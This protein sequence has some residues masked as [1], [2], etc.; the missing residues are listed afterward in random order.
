MKRCLSIVFLLTIIIHILTAKAAVA[1]SVSLSTN[2]VLQGGTVTVYWSGFSGGTNVY[3]YNGSYW[4]EANT[5]GGG[6]GEQNLV[7]TGYAVRADYRVRVELKANTSID[8]YSEFFSVN[9]PSASVS[10]SSVVVGGT[11]TAFWSGFASDVNVRLYRNSSSLGEVTTTGAGSDQQNLVMSGYSASDYYRVMVELKAN[12]NI[13]KWS[14]YFSVTE[15]PAPATPLG[16]S[17]ADVT[18]GFRLNW[19]NVPGTSGSSPYQIYWGTSS[20]VTESNKS[21]VI[22]DDGTPSD[23]V[24]LSN[25]STYCYRIKACNGLSCSGLSSP[26][27]CKVYGMLDGPALIY[28][29]NNTIVNVKTF[30][31]RWSPVAN[32]VTYEVLVDNNLGYGSAEIT[33]VLNGIT[34]ST[35]LD[36]PFPDNVYFWQVRAKLNDGTYTQW[37]QGQ[38]TYLNPVSV[39]PVWVPLYRLYKG[40]AI[41][42]HYYTTIPQHRDNMVQDGYIY[43]KVEGYISNRKYDDQNCGYL[44]HLWDATNQIN[45]YTTSESDKDAKIISGFSYKGIVGFL[46]TATS[47]GMVPLYHAYK[48]ADTDNFYTVSNSEYTLAVS[49]GYADAQHIVGYV[50]LSPVSNTRPQGSLMG[51]DLFSGAFNAGPFTDLALRGAGPELTF[52]RYYSSYNYADFPLSAGWKHNHFNYIDEGIDGRVAIKWGNGDENHFINNGSNSFT[53][54]WGTFGT[55]VRDTGNDSYIYTSKD[56]LIYTFKRQ[57]VTYMPSTQII[58]DMLLAS[59][60]DKNNNELEYI[61]YPGTGFLK[62]VSKKLNGSSSNQSLSFEYVSTNN[63]FRLLKVT[64]NALN[65]TISFDYDTNNLLSKYFDARGNLTTYVYDAGLLTNIT[66]P[67]GNSTAVSYD[68]SQRAYSAASGGVNVGFGYNPNNTTAET[69]QGSIVHTHD[70][71]FRIANVQYPDMS[72]VVPTYDTGATTLYLP[73]SVKDRNGNT[74]EYTYDASGN[75]KTAK[76]VALNQTTHY[77]YDAKNNLTSVRDA[78]EISTTYTYDGNMVNIM[79]VRK[80]LGG[81]TYFTYYANGRVWTATDPN[82]HTFV[83][84]YDGNGNLINI[85]DNTL[86]T[87][88][89][90]EYDYAGRMKS[91]TDQMGMTTSFLYDENDNLKQVTDSNGGVAT[92]TFDMNNRLTHV[93]DPKGQSTGKDTTYGYNSLDQLVSV[94]DQIG[95]A[96]GYAYDAKGN[97]STVNEPGGTTLTYTYNPT[98]NRPHG[99]KLNGTTKITY[100]NYDNN[101]NLKSMTD[102]NGTTLFDYDALNRISSYSNSYVGHAVSYGYDAS[103]NMNKTSYPGSKDVVY[104]YDADNRLST[105]T[106]WLPGDPTSYHYDPAGNLQSVNNPNGTT[107]TYSFDLANRLTGLANKKANGSVFSSYAFTLNNVGNPTRSIFDQPGIPTLTAANITSTFDDANKLTN[108]GGVQYDYD[109]EGNLF[110]YGGNSFSFDYANRLTQANIGGINNLYLYDGFGNRIART[111]GDTQTKYVLDVNG[112]M[113]D[114]LAETDSGGNILNYYIYGHGLISKIDAATNQRHVYHYDTLGNTIAITDPSGNVIT[115]Q[116]GYDE[117]GKA[118]SV[119]ETHPNPFRYVGKYGVMDEGNGLLF[120]RAR[121][122]D[123]ENGRFISKDPIG[124]EGGDLNLYSYVMGNPVVGVDPGGLREVKLKLGAPSFRR[125]FGST[126]SMVSNKYSESLVAIENRR[127]KDSSDFCGSS[128]WTWIFPDRWG[129]ID[130]KEFCK[131]HDDCYLRGENQFSCDKKLGLGIVKGNLSANPTRA[132]S[133]GVVYFSGVAMFGNSYTN[134]PKK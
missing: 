110:G 47:E 126:I 49:R 31:L 45:Y 73:K 134:A 132:L 38:F 42:D 115:E 125:L 131:A 85:H 111:K 3:F 90:M 74:T 65:R 63:Y 23:H 112:E 123:V 122:Y 84:Y 55:L 87:D 62:S 19:N 92:F 96:Y 97:L 35:A 67:E 12:V 15:P 72:T 114:V 26:E 9:N 53:E 44:M 71:Q 34:T 40:G 76:I 17:I 124:F 2:A 108:A 130:M 50:S 29:A 133:V 127:P 32:V 119:S 58:P 109:P 88:F 7:M 56:Q 6:S 116:Y 60:S 14:N 21:E 101:G 20:G 28:P 41:K 83:Y 78:R 105:V 46:Y 102:G 61:Y 128:N 118:L 103:G 69:P 43:E 86:G 39:S 70:T 120:M 8:K 27:V 89:S 51:V 81:T 77:Y 25:G 24:G 68:G 5:T 117:Y 37:S 100:N 82:S 66:Y 95:S 52:T 93:K 48:P 107:S 91:K 11:T 99:L 59:V 54:I 36:S 129:D 18:G 4:V 94:T 16:L 13:Y 64:D 1:Q 75:V 33:R 106:D 113:S 104:V 10:P 22:N 57:P 30:E 80:P 121:Y 79:S 98:D